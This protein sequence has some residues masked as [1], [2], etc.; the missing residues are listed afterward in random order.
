MYPQERIAKKK[1]PI[2]NLQRA[3][4]DDEEFENF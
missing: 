2:N 3:L 1:A 4:L